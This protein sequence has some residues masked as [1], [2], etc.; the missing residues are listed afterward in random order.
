MRIPNCAVI[1]VCLICLGGCSRANRAN[2]AAAGQSV[3]RYQL[4]EEPATLDPALIEAGTTAELMQNVFEGLIILDKNARPAPGLA[5]RWEIS[6]DGKTYTF[7][8][9]PNAKF[10]RPINRPLT[11]ADVKWSFERS[12]WPETKSPIIAPLL[13]DIEGAQD[14]IAGRTRDL[15]GVTL[16]DEH[17]VRITLVGP[18][19]YFLVS[20]AGAPIMCRESVEKNGGRIDDH[21]CIGT[22]PFMFKEYR[23]GAHVVL[24]ANPDYWGGRP[25]V[26]RIERPI[27]IDADT[28]HVKYETND[29]NLL[30]DIAKDFAQDSKN[31]SYSGQCDSVPAAS[32]GFIA[33]NPKQE[34]AFG[35]VRVRRAIAMAIDRKEICRVA[36]YGLAEPAVGILPPGVIGFNPGLRAIP[37]D[38]G[39]AQKLLAEAGYPDGQGF[40]EQ[41]LYYVQK[42]PEVE[43]LA[44][45]VRDMLKKNLNVSINLQA[46]EAATFYSDSSKGKMAFYTEGWS[47]IDPR[48]FLSFLLRTGSKYNFI[49]YSS[50]EFD[51]ICDTADME[52]D[53][54]KRGALYYKANQIAVNDVAILPYGHVRSVFLHKPSVA[55]V[56]FNLG[57][58]MPHYTTRVVH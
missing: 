27:V 48:D 41:T 17:T 52:M 26:D 28:A 44:Q 4:Q 42:A 55:G 46:R 31:P 51:R 50:R 19:G 7:H 20:P 10:H 43:S 45:L 9:R 58:I 1:A 29:L 40:P 49:G 39:A 34:K 13:V 35:D 32:V 33:M 12:L 37:F 3:L 15:L 8:L 21:S 24:E 5:E 14:V 53:E 6:P 11:A 38:P 54:K 57:G 56:Q 47:A 30:I 25:P 18:R 16:V 22:G 2:T 23:H 36:F